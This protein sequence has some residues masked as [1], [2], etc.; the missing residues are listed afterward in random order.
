[1][2]KPIKQKR[3]NQV[4]SSYYYLFWCAMCIAVVSGQVYVGSGYRQMAGSVNE[5]TG[6]INRIFRFVR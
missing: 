2:K 3:M 4:K 1:M 5:L 6:H